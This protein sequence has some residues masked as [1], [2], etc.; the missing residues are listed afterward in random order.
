MAFVYCNNLIS[1]SLHAIVHIFFI[2]RGSLGTY[3]ADQV[4][5]PQLSRLVGIG[6]HVGL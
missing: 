6:H 4:H 2:I 3:I 5:A 1:F